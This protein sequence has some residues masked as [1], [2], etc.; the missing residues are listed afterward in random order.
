MAKKPNAPQFEEDDKDPLLDISSMTNNKELWLIQWPV[1][2]NT[3]LDGQEITLK[4]QRNGN[5]ASFE[6]LSGKSY[7]LVSFASQVHDA[8]VFQSLASDTKVGAKELALQSD[9]QLADFMPMKMQS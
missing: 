7:E 6:T 9:W 8:T 5:F 1:N 3:D 2:Q 4:L